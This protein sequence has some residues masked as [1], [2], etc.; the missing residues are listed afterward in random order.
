MQRISNWL[1]DD[2]KLFVHIFCHDRETYLFEDNGPTDWMTRYFFSGGIMP[3]RDLLLRYQQHLTLESQICWDGTH[4]EKTSNA[5][6][7]AMDANASVVESCFRAAYGA[8]WQKWVQRWRMFY[9]ACAEL[10]GF[11]GGQEWYVSHYLFGRK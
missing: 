9:M 8:D 4:Y 10:F 2:G 3:S 5:W 6:L 11:N 7:N 1:K